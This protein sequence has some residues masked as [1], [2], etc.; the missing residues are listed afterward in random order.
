MIKLYGHPMSTCTR[1][2]L[3][4]LHETNTP[5]ELVVVDFAKGEH[6]QPAHVARQPWG[7]V[8]ALDHD[9]F[10]LYESRAMSRYIDGLAGGK[11]TPT[12]KKRDAVME[13]WISVETENFTPNAMKFVYH[14][15]FQRPQADDVLAK[16]A[17][18]LALACGVLDKALAG[19][20]YL[21]G[22]QFTLGDICYAP[23]IEYA[24]NNAT[25]KDIFG[26]NANVMSWWGRVSERPAWRK[27]AG[28]A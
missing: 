5:F 26:K 1:K 9:G 24:M 19:K 21:V 10:A 13:Q 7:K 27:A 15:V 25:A 3:C 11:L 8:P 17:E 16:A 12:D 14:T 22:D 23:Y 20:T 4:T 28:R 6:K 18:G 2:V